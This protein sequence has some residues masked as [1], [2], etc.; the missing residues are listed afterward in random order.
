MQILF[1][2]SDESFS[3]S[4]GLSLIDAD[5]QRLTSSLPAR[6]PHIGWS[7]ISI[8]KEGSF[9]SE[10]MNGADFYFV[11]SYALL[12]SKVNRHLFDE[13]S[14]SS[15]GNCTFISSF[16]FRNLYGCQ[17]HPEKSSLAGSALLQNFIES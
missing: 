8:Q 10:S 17:F 14:L 11:H 3:F 1:N 9:L 15:N 16:R 6:I 12:D 4:K 7:S 5:I 2:R 13:F